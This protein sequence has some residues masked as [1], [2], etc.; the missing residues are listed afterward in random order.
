M[1]YQLH[2]DRLME[3]ARHRALEGYSERHHVIPKCLGGNNKKLNI[4]RLTPEEHYVAHQLLVKIH[5]THDGLLGA[6]IMMTSGS[7]MLH[8]RNK[9]YGW[10]RR[11]FARKMKTFRHSSETVK[12]VAAINRTKVRSDEFKQGVADFHR[13]RKRPPETGIKIAASAKVRC[14]EVK[15]KLGY[16]PGLTVP[17]SAE[18]RAKMSAWRTGRPVSD[19]HKVAM[20]AGW[21]R[22]RARLSAEAIDKEFPDQNSP[23]H[24]ISAKP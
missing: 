7:T 8:R 20:K 9:V 19:A 24:E 18:T 21:V 5:P 6:A 22:R 17:R 1:N 12:R 2:Y 4:V 15:A 14:A 16:I 10:L 23:L 13:G 11:R 3:R